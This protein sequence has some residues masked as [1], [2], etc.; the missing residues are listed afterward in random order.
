MYGKK[1]LRQEL[2]RR[3][4]VGERRLSQIIAARAAELPSTHDEALFTIAYENRLR[5]QDY[6]TPEQITAT[7]ALVKVGSAA[8]TAAPTK[9]NGSRPARKSPPKMV[10]V[11]VTGV[12]IGDIPGL[13]HSHATEAKAMAE[14]V[15]PL[16]YFFENSV[17]DVIELVLA[18]KHGAGWWDAAVPV[19]VREAAVEIKAKEQKDTWHSKRGRR[20][21]DYLLLTQLW[22]IIHARW[23]DF[24]PF[25]PQ[26][27]AWVQSMIENDMNVS[28][29]VFAHMNP[30]EED[31]IKNLE[32]S[33]RKWVK[34]LSA[35]A[36]KLPQPQ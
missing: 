6:L 17:R 34:H 4:N 12:K 2:R 27:Q 32:A 10:S 35:V 23:K 24:E 1:E 3:L 33:F 5:L 28:R 18:D 21:I 13:K 9:A 20:P 30:L 7:R 16:L 11:T 25:F 22:K 36:D 15:Y 14:R 26:G 31:D 29:A 8:S 19:K